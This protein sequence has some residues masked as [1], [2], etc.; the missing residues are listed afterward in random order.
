M[1]T[2]I[3]KSG[4]RSKLIGIIVMRIKCDL[5]GHSPNLCF[6]QQLLKKLQEK[7]KEVDDLMVQ[8]QTEKV[9]FS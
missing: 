9:S 7:E 1:Y 6:V 4:G 3:E 8:I 2:T 5:S